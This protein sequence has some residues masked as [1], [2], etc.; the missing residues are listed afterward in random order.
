MLTLSSIDELK[1]AQDSLT[2]L[3]QSKPDLFEKY[4][5]VLHLTR[6][7]QFKY[8]YMGH[9]LMGQPPNHSHPN[10]VKDSVLQL[11]ANQIDEL[12]NDRAF[13]DLKQLLLEHQHAGH[14]K[15]SMLAL[16]TAPESLVGVSVIS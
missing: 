13:A 15:I 12:K 4:L 1:H 3:H 8:D 5:H 10:H 6:Q 16:G 7:L 9:L 2:A 14:A 11:Y